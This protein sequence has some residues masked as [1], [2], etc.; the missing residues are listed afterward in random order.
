MLSSPVVSTAP[1]YPI[2][3]VA[4][5][6]G[7]T[8]LTLRAW[9][10]RYAA[11]APARSDGRQRLFSDADVERLTLLR[12][13]T[14]QGT[15]ISALA[16][17]STAELRGMAPEVA[18][19]A[20]PAREE[21]R[22]A[23]ALSRDLAVCSRAVAALDADRLHQVLMRLVLERG[24]LPFLE[25]VAS[26]LFG[27]IGDE[28]SLGRLSEAQEHSASEVLRRVFAFML[29]TLRRERRERHVVLTTL[30]GERHEFGAMMAGIVAAYDGWSYHYLG[31][32][33]PATA[34]AAAVKRLDARLLAVSIVAP[35]GAT[36][37]SREL[38]ALRRALG[39]GRRVEIVVGG[40]SSATVDHVLAVARATRIA[41]LREWR[42][43]LA[44]RP[45]GAMAARRR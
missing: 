5:R 11:V 9:E 20:A 3:V 8:E 24:P 43:L 17:L 41:S 40:P 36:Q 29:Q 26:P 45:G 44:Q 4:R 33:L 15:P 42:E 13:L 10:R 38:V 34:I 28:W 27:W 2:R 18:E 21:H 32:D 25:E 19:R 12:A 23:P 31:P 6:V 35:L 1:R 14:H 16:A 30:A 7:I 39:G 22:A 37:P